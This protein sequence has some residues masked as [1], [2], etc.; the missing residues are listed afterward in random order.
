MLSL[1]AAGLTGA[2]L[3]IVLMWHVAPV[4]ALLTAPFAGS[5]AAG[6]AGLSLHWLRPR[7][8]LCDGSDLA[9]SMDTDMMVSA[10]R[11]AAELGRRGRGVVPAVRD[12]RRRAM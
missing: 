7:D 2:G 9:P 1:V 4:L 6:C 8:G 10:L 12:Q 5:L 11:G 3:A